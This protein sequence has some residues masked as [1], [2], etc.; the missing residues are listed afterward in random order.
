MYNCS[1]ISDQTWL[2]IWFAIGKCLIDAYA[3]HQKMEDMWSMQQ[4]AFK[5][6]YLLD[7]LA[8]E[9][10]GALSMYDRFF[11]SCLLFAWGEG[12]ILSKQG[13]GDHMWWCRYVLY[14]CKISGD[15]EILWQKEVWNPSSY[16]LP[17]SVFHPFSLLLNVLQLHID[18]FIF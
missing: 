7:D 3:R 5:E 14:A 2:W 12:R 15:V 17:A 11:W 9:Q 1:C 6:W 13:R 8:H 18:L 16:M 10:I 4:D